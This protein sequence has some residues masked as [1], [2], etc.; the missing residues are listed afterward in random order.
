M[1]SFAARQRIAT[2]AESMSLSPKL[3]SVN[4]TVS[5]S[6][7]TGTAPSSSILPRVFRAFR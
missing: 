5:F 2:T 4:D 7:T 6:F 3:I 1:T